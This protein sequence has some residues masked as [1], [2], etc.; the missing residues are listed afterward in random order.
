MSF[1]GQV[2]ED[3]I[4]EVAMEGGSYLSEIYMRSVTEGFVWANCKREC[5]YRRL[6]ISQDHHEK[7]TTLLG[8]SVVRLRLD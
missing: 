2:S 3:V 5:R 1:W 6:L 8:A 7:P 4:V